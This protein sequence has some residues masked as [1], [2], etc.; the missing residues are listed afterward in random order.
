V[1]LLGNLLGD[2]LSGLF[3]SG[4]LSSSLLGSGHCVIYFNST[5]LGSI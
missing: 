2:S 5:T 1:A 3:S 4:V